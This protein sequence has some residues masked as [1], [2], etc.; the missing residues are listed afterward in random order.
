MDGDIGWNSREIVPEVVDKLR[1]FKRREIEYRTSGYVRI[2]SQIGGGLHSVSQ[3]ENLDNYTV[4]RLLFTLHLRR[5][6]IAL[7][8]SERHCLKTN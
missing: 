1:P 5:V 6:R 2:L 7:H 4:A 8:S 3:C